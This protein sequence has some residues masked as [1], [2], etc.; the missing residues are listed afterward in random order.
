MLSVWKQLTSWGLSYMK[1]I[2]KWPKPMRPRDVFSFLGLTNFIGTLLKVIHRLL[3][4]YLNL[5]TCI[6]T[7]AS[8]KGIGSGIEGQ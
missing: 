3:A 4:H 7:D 2:T 6:E 5:H 1:T 8:G